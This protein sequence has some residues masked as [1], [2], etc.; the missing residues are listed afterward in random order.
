MCIIFP[1]QDYNEPLSALSLTTLIMIHLYTDAHYCI[2]LEL[3]L[4][5]TGN[6]VLHQS[7]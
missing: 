1:A 3:C 5:G 7:I 6:M 2:C 4:V